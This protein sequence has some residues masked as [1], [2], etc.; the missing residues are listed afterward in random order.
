MDMDSNTLCLFAKN[1]RYLV[2]DDHGLP[3]IFESQR[4]IARSFEIDHTTISKKLKM[5]P[6]GDVFY[7]RS[8]N[9]LY[10]IMKV[11][12]NPIS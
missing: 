2:I 6:Y 9:N 3:Y 12:N 11:Y 10:Y 5:H 1:Q 4:D 7:T 8:N